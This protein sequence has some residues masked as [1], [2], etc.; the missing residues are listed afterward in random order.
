[1]DFLLQNVK[2][3][4]HADASDEIELRVVEELIEKT[5][6][7]TKRVMYLSEFLRLADSVD[8]SN[9]Y[10]IGSI[11][12]VESW[13]RKYHGIKNEN[14]IEI[15]A[16]LRTDEFLKR[17]YRLVRWDEVPT[18][19]KFFL[20]DASEL[21]KF[22]YS[23]YLDNLNLSES[24]VWV[25]EA[26]YLK[27]KEDERR[28]WN[29]ENSQSEDVSDYARDVEGDGS[30]LDGFGWESSLK[31]C[32]QHKYVLSQYR[33]I[34]SEYRVYVIDNNISAISLYNGDPCIFPDVRLLR[35]AISLIELN[36]KWLKSYTID[37]MITKEGTSIIEIHDFTSIGLYSTLWGSDLLY[38]YRQGIDYLLNDNKELS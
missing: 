5:F 37:V 1:M 7:H 19:G 15:P 23:G 4:R 12:F 8:L 16:Y 26:E 30:G 35:K 28:A 29:I 11:P 20:K 33:D 32:K 10:P 22:T 17:D 36:E 14:P 31:L 3:D 38:A 18:H 13:L 25:D 24:G 9:H 21:K 34:I 6:N 2:G 27:L